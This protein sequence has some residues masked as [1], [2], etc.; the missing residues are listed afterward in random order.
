MEPPQTRPKL[1]R[2]RLDLNDEER[3]FIG[4]AAARERLSM[5]QYARRLVQ[6]AMLREAGITAPTG[7]DGTPES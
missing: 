4:V 1:T 7:A 6:Q 5:A 2:V 3:D